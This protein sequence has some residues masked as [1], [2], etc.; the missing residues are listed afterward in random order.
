M[1]LSTELQLLLISTD[2]LTLKALKAAAAQLGAGLSCMAG[3]DSGCDY[4][5]RRKVDGI[6]LDL[7]VAGWA[8]VVGALRLGT[9]NHYAVIFACVANRL[10]AQ[11][12]RAIGAHLVLHKPLTVNDIIAKVQDSRELMVR[13][14]RRY[15]RHQAYMPVSLTINGV[16]QHAL[17]TNISEG[18]MAV[19][20]TQPVDYCA[21]VDFAFQLRT[22]P[23]ITGRGN[24]AWRDNE[25]IVG[26]GFQFLRDGG[27][28]LLLNWLQ[29]Q[30]RLIT[31]HPSWTA[32]S[33]SAL[34]PKNT[35]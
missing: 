28:E 9:S 2:Y 20:V 15:F 27:K 5:S 31:Q 33:S 22:G 30:E 35:L 25:R 24:V 26:I 8:S 19:R 7:D 4:V 14:R 17:I 11:E 3:A 23:A 16:E 12:A 21:L 34:S 18:G 13:E 29:Q 6:F 32:E 10:A 1:P